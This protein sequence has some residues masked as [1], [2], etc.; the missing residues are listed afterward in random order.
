VHTPAEL[1]DTVALLTGDDTLRSKWERAGKAYADRHHAPDRV[2]DKY[3]S[4][5]QSLLRDDGAVRA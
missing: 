2:L 4:L 1:R 5:L 3:E